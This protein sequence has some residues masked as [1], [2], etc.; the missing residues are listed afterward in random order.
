[1]ICHKCS[2]M[3][4]NRQLVTD[5][6]ELEQEQR[7]QMT[8][9]VAKL[10][11][12]IL[13]YE[14]EIRQQTELKDKNIT[15]IKNAETKMTHIVEEWIRDLREHE[16]KMKQKFCEIY[17][18]EQKQHATRLENLELIT[19]QLRSFVERAQR[20]LERNISAEILQTNHS[21][22]GRC[23]QL[24]NARKSDRY[25]SPF[26]SYFVKRKF[27]IF[28]QILVTK[29]DSSM[30]LA[31]FDDSKIGRELNVVVVT[32]DSE[33]LQCYQEDDQ[34]KVDILTSEGDHLETVLKDSKDGK[35]SMTYTPECSGQY[36]VEVQVNGQQLISR[37]C[38]VHVHHHQYKFAFQFESTEN[39]PLLFYDMNNIAVS[40]KTGTIAVADYWNQR[41]R[42]FRS[43]G[44]FQKDVRIKDGELRSVA[45]VCCGE[46][47]TLVSGTNSRLRLLS[48][49]GQ[50]IKH[51][52]DKHLKEPQRLSI[53]SD[54]RLIITEE[55]NKEVKILS[56]DGNN[57]LLS[58]TAPD[59]DKHPKCAVYHQ[60]KFYVSYS[61]VQCIKVFDKTGVYLHDIGCGG[62]NDGQFD[63]PYGLV[64]DKFNR[65]IVCDTNNRRLQVFTLSGKFLGV[66]EFPCFSI[67]P[68]WNAVISKNGNLFV[69]DPWGGFVSCF[70]LEMFDEENATEVFDTITDKCQLQ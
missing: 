49:K 67:S 53:A 50:F 40:D 25:K 19:T 65:L 56:S 54:G 13:L 41:I 17:E 4:H 26:L 70:S 29:T 10:K 68:P 38:V 62:T 35:Y 22:L 32:R 58:F 7:R 33:G 6:Q 47:L 48:E 5:T 69:S 51:I 15:D 28:G 1:M 52:N 55:T 3:S 44:K 20:V 66:L 21:I 36:R 2:E 43:D 46:L 60:N 31:E 18:A 30:C 16:K 14:N 63:V 39:G 45:F 37:P 61:A 57:L 11:A 59:C 9:A 8:E 64:I 34:I 24:L 12:E 27:D 42:L 23:D